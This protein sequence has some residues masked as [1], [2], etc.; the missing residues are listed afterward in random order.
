MSITLLSN[1]YHRSD[2]SND[3]KVQTVKDLVNETVIGVTETA[4]WSDTTPKTVFPLQG[5]KNFPF[6][7]AL[8][9]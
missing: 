6:H 1:K 7:L 8:A 9:P 2:I 4:F 3:Q 5:D